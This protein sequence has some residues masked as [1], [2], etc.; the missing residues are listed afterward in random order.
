MKNAEE[1]ESI[2][3]KDKRC[4]Q[5]NHKGNTVYV[6]PTSVE[7]ALVLVSTMKQKHEK[8]ISDAVEAIVVMGKLISDS[9][10]KLKTWEDLRIKLLNGESSTKAD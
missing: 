5:A 3:K 4:Y 7:R 9:K 2:T 6:A 10:E 1:R 8:I